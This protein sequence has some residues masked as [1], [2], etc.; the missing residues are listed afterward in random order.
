MRWDIQARLLKFLINENVVSK[1]G[2][3]GV[4][5]S[6]HNEKGSGIQTSGKWWV[7]VNKS[8]LK[9]VTVVSASLAFVNLSKSSFF[10]THSYYDV[11]RARAKPPSVLSFTLWPHTVLHFL[12]FITANKQ[13]LLRGLD[14]HAIFCLSTK[15]GS[16][17]IR[18]KERSQSKS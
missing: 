1:S 3:I 10:L 2:W 7:P 15:C 12:P 18:K 4:V 17:E 9:T 6:W 8:R 13:L 14:K 5:W 16:V 11:K